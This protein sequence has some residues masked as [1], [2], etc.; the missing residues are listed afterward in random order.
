MAL[1]Q[2]DICRDGV[3]RFQKY[4]IPWHEVALLGLAADAVADDPRARQYQLLEPLKEPLCLVFLVDSDDRVDQDDG[5]EN[6]GPALIVEV[7]GKCCGDEQQAD[8]Q[9]VELV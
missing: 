4:D 8:Q 9:I 1:D 2:P 6:R 3:T 7:I 5:D